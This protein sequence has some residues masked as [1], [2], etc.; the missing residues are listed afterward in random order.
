MRPADVIHAQIRW[1]PRLDDR[2][3][4]IGLDVHAANP[5]EILFAGFEPNGDIPW[6]RVLY[7]A[8]DGV[9]CWDRRTG[10]DHVDRL[11]DDGVASSVRLGPPWS[12]RAPVRW[13]GQRWSA[14]AT[15]PG[16]TAEATLT[17]VTWNVL[18]DRF[19][20]DAID[21]ARR[22]PLLLD[23]LLDGD[24][25]VLALQEVDP[26]FR[27]LV[28]AD[29]RVREDW[30]VSH[31]PRH[32]DVGDRDLMLLGRCAV[33]QVAMLPFDAHKGALALVLAGDR[34]VTVVTTHLS[35]NHREGA[36]AIRASELTTLAAG[37]ADRE[38]PVVVVGDFNLRDETPIGDLRDA[39]TELHPTAPT[40]EPAANPL[41]ALASRTGASGRL[42]RVL[43]RGDVTCAQIERLGTSPVDGT[44][45]SDHYGV[46]A[47]L[48]F[49]VQEGVHDGEP[50]VRSALAWVPAS[51]LPGVQSVRR[52]H[53]P[54][55]GRWPPHI[56]VLWGFV[57]ETAMDDA[58]PLIAQA[59]ADIRP[60]PSVL[61]H[62]GAFGRG[63][64][65]THHLAP[66]EVAPWRALHAPLARAFPRTVARPTFHPHLTVARGTPP[67]ELTDLVPAGGVVDELVWMTRRGRGPFVVRARFPLG[68]KQWMRMEDPAP[69]GLNENR[70]ARVGAV[71]EAL[72]DALPGGRLELVG[73]RRLG[74][75]HGRS[76]VDLLWASDVDVDQAV[77]HLGTLGATRLTVVEKNGL[78]GIQLVVDQIPVDLMVA[79]PDDLSLPAVR[80]RS[81]VEDADALAPRLAGRLELVREVKRWAASHHLDDASLGGLEGLAWAVLVAETS[82]TTLAEFI[83]H[84]AAYDWSNPVG[85]IEAPAPDGIA[86]ATPTAPIGSIATR[87][88]RERLERALLETW[89][90][91]ESG[92]PVVPWHQRWTHAI[93]VLAPELDARG[94]V[95]GRS[96]GVVEALG[97][98]DP[99]G[100]SDGVAFGLPNDGSRET[101]LQT[102]KSV[103][104][105]IRGI[106][107][108]LVATED[109]D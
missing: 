72:R 109:V 6:H 33:E 21:S 57:A 13:D 42:D 68:T 16:R 12:P 76:D 74:V 69:T 105:G 61:D 65:A 24:A 47:E 102:V 83:A 84:W 7:F 49:G 71:I 41:A 86:I 9:P 29:H 34:P 45:L 53:D 88:L 3:F 90:A 48:V 103:L 62:V 64:R 73:S 60:F 56:N 39:W 38:H 59:L 104:R 63:G 67:E 54:A 20:P 23:A 43:I 37:L 81:A 22:W 27:D 31:G 14:N 95:R 17:L 97:S 70:E 75:H 46:R 26:A 28:L 92:E 96:R 15:Q 66:A 8:C 77:E 100:L 89:E 106:K 51:P 82:A 58:G 40:F 4:S 99:R 36:V 52:R 55:F 85:A 30:W 78:R 2:R 79:N 87:A 25:D 5:K 94:A 98:C 32:P 18:W 93:R 10:V 107:V 19:D 35:S 101:A 11:A 1:D 91:L 80:A 108:R 44:W 50:T